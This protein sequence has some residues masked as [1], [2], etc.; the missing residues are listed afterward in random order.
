MNSAARVIWKLTLGGLMKYE[1]AAET[2]GGF[3]HKSF[4]SICS[5]PVNARFLIPIGTVKGIWVHLSI[6]RKSYAGP[7]ELVQNEFNTN[8]FGNPCHWQTSY[9]LQLQ[10]AHHHRSQHHS[11]RQHYTVRWLRG[12]QAIIIKKMEQTSAGWFT[13]IRG[14]RQVWSFSIA[15]PHCPLICL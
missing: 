9:P 7:Y 1:T 11:W 3:P 8:C 15:A 4:S 12:F 6:Q 2:N 13:S 14:C 10:N 5:G